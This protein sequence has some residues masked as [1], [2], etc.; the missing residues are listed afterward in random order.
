MGVLFRRHLAK[1]TRC[2]SPPLNL[3]PLSPTY[4]MMNDDD[5][6]DDD[7]D[8]INDDDINDDDDD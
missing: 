3:R 7:D 6:R 5:D 4:R 8:D 2:F 1:A